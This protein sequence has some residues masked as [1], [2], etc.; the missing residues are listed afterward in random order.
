MDRESR[1]KLL[2]DLVLLLNRVA[3]C[4]Q[5]CTDAGARY[6]ADPAQI[7][8]LVRQARFLSDSANAFRELTRLA[9]DLEEG[10]PNCD[11]CSLSAPSL[12][13]LKILKAR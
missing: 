1:S 9:R 10:V 6:Q 8:Y 13:L 4:A 11:R 2:D 5:R 7:T 12:E 3:D